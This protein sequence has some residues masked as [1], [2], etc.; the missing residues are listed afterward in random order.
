M[1]TEPESASSSLRSGGAFGCLFSLLLGLAMGFVIFIGSV[2]GDCEP[3]PG[4]HDNDDAVIAGGLL[5]AAPIVLGFG[6]GAWL[7]LSGL[8][9]LLRGRMSP[10]ALNGLL[11]ILTVALAWLC[12][13]PAFELFF[14]MDR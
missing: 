4:C 8:H 13:E 14:L 10:L 9:A 5:Q 7:V 3:G 2:M 1:S 6:L 12:F 11:S